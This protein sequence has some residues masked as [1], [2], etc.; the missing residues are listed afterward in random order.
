MLLI[1]TGNPHK[2]DELRALLPGVP[3]TSL[4]AWPDA[5]E[6][7]EDAPDFAGNAIIKARSAH[8]H[9]GLVSLGDDSGIEVEALGWAPGVRSARYAP[10]S[11]ADRV[12]A[13]L[14]AMAGQPERRARF[15]CAIAIAGL[16][17]TLE[18]PAGVER[19]DG[20]VVGLGQV[21]GTLTEA[22]RGEGGFGYDP[23]FELPDG[24]S[25]AEH[26]PGEKHALSHR[27]RAMAQLTSLITAF[28]LDRRVGDR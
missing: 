20:C 10:G 4:A 23:I 1:A 27:G 8:A 17:A 26:T 15:T 9:T 18:L 6:P 19:I 25:A 22:P 24:R 16:P 28:F 5:P 12:Q 3:L 11:D 14:R 7:V 21:Y 2:V 13:L